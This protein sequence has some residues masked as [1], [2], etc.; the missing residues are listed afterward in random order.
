MKQAGDR[1]TKHQHAAFKNDGF[2]LGW[3]GYSMKYSVPG[4]KKFTSVD[5]GVNN[6]CTS[7]TQ[8]SIFPEAEFSLEHALAVGGTYEVCTI[9]QNNVFRKLKLT[10]GIAC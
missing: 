3:M 1:I 6:T 7:F 8:H 4:K 10:A 5:Y 2:G 9:Q